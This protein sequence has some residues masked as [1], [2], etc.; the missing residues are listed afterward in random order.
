[1]GIL[2]PT[3]LQYVLFS[4]GRRSTIFLLL[5]RTEEAL[6]LATP[7]LSPVTRP[8]GAQGDVLLVEDDEGVERVLLGS[9][10]PQ[11]A[12]GKTVEA[13]ERLGLSEEEKY[14]IRFGNARRLLGRQCRE[15]KVQC[16]ETP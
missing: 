15:T 14:R 12:L 10:Y 3:T 5:P 4:L 7:E 6:P 16:Q 11:M 9:D 13:F 2:R 8:P 1:M